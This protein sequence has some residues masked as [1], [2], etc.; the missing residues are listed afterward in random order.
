MFFASLR[1]AAGGLTAA[2]VLAV[3]A[4][5][6]AAPSAS[7]VGS[8]ACTKNIADTTRQITRWGDTILRDGPGE[9]YRKKKTLFTGEKVRLY[10]RAYNKHTATY[11]YYG[12][13]GTTKGWIDEYAF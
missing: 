13:N 8:S 2:T 1:K 4:T 5:V 12:K 6:L 3:G 11:W 7:A 10:C 9:S